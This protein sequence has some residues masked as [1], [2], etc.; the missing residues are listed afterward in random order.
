MVLKILLQCRYINSV[1]RLSSIYRD[2]TET[3]LKRAVYWTEFVIRHKGADHLRLGSRDLNFLQRNLFDVF[4]VLFILAIT[5]LLLIILC[6]RRC[7]CQRIKKTTDKQP[8]ST[9]KKR[10]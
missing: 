8:S 7:C 10:K 6:V 2:Q 5:P 9:S 1:K 4:L 3:P